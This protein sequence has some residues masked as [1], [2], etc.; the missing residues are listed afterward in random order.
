MR[1]LAGALGRVSPA[2]RA[3]LAQRNF[4]QGADRSLTS[5][6]PDVLAPCLKSSALGFLEA[7]RAGDR[8]V[9]GFD[10]A[11]RRVPYDSHHIV[12]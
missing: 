9:D 12:F 4:K 3:G 1:L 6:A 2:S 7:A 5:N 10:S 11:G 8:L